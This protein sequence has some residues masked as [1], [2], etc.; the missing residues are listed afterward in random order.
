M[1]W[2]IGGADYFKWNTKGIGGND[3]QLFVYA[4]NNNG[5][6]CFGVSPSPNL[7][8]V[9]SYR[10]DV[11]TGIGATPGFSNMVANAFSF[12]TGSEC[13]VI[14][15]ANVQQG[16]GNT[17][18]APTVAKVISHPIFD[19]DV[20]PF[21]FT[22]TTAP[23]PSA[24][25]LKYAIRRDRCSIFGDSENVSVTGSGIVMTMYLPALSA[26]AKVNVS[27]SVYSGSWSP[28]LAY[29][30]NQSSRGRLD[31]AKTGAG[32]GW[33]GNETSVYINFFTEYPI[34]E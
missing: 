2:Y 13:R 7:T 25:T 20:M 17:W 28:V 22:T 24:I 19:T 11:F 18:V 3:A 29:V 12:A 21:T 5:T 15:R 10:T 14:G 6:L 16:T 23:T 31:I 9:G 27:A 1:Q 30:I 26:M 33:V 34:N 4:I 32:G 8:F